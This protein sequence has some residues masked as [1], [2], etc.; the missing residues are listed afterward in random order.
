MFVL[1]VGWLWKL[2]DGWCM[3]IYFGKIWIDDDG[4]VI[5]WGVYFDD[6]LC[7]LMDGLMVVFENL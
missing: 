7:L 6:V 4:N 3:D 1:R 5:V 2:F